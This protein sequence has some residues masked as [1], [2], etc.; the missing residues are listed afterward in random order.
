[1][2]IFKFATCSSHPPSSRLFLSSDSRTIARKFELKTSKFV[3]EI[4]YYI[5]E[6]EF[7]KTVV[8]HLNL[9]NQL[10]WATDDVTDD[11]AASL[12]TFTAEEAAEYREETVLS[13]S[14]TAEAVG[15]PVLVGILL[16]VGGGRPHGIHFH[17]APGLLNSCLLLV[18]H[19][20]DRGY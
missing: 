4:S 6:Q 9:A 7:G 12:A 14:S 13:C 17:G 11:V 5:Q 20:L 10:A 15:L 1:M 3:V 16:L 2:L 18:L 19:V 8:K